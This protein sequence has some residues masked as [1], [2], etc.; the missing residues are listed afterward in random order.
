MF[1]GAET[2][3]KKKEKRKK[4]YLATPVGLRAVHLGWIFSF[5]S[6]PADQP[7]YPLDTRCRVALFFGGIG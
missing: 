7:F 2:K 6:R 5:S 3:K 4:Y 1:S